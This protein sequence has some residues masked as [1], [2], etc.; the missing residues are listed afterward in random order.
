MA[1][2]LLDILSGSSANDSVELAGLRKKRLQEMKHNL[3]LEKMYP[4]RSFSGATPSDVEGLESDIADDPYTGLNAQK[5]VRK[6]EGQLADE[7]AFNSP[8]ATGVR[9]IKQTDK[10]AELLAVPKQQGENALKVAQETSRGNEAVARERNRPYEMMAGRTSGG[11]GGGGLPKLLGMGGGSGSGGVMASSLK[12]RVAGNATSLDTLKKLKN[13][14][15]S[16]YV[17]P[18]E[19]RAREFGQKLPFVP[20]D[21][22]FAAFSAN[23][24]TLT[25]AVI[26][27]ITGAQMSEPEAKRIKGQIPSVEDK[28]EVWQ[29]KAQ[30]TEDNLRMMMQKIYELHGQESPY[31]QGGDDDSVD[32]FDDP[33]WGMQ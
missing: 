15:R 27:A 13:D 33:N 21:K 11:I 26:K 7:A 22:K 25:N 12:E 4:G 3:D 18:V 2:S 17:G 19:G 16:E 20:V 31:G 14:F 28:P 6:I 8:G 5:D 29:A 23:T 32:E 9:N 10:L 24:S 30:A 1:Q